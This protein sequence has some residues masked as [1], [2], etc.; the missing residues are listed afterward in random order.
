MADI[1]KLEPKRE[2]VERICKKVWR[3][4]EEVKEFLNLLEVKIECE[5]KRAE[6]LNR[7]SK[8]NLNYLKK[9]PFE[10]I[11]KS[12]IK[13]AEN[14]AYQT[15]ELVESLKNV[16]YEPLKDKVKGFSDKIESLDDCFEDHFKKL[17][18]AKEKLISID[19]NYSHYSQQLSD[20]LKKMGYDS[21]DRKSDFFDDKLFYSL[22][23]KMKTVDIRAKEVENQTNELNKLVSSYKT[24]M[25][26]KIHD[27][28]EMEDERIQGIIDALNQMN[29]FQTNC[30][31]NNKY[32]CNHF[33]QTVE[34]IKTDQTVM[35]YKALFDPAPMLNIQT[36]KFKLY[37]ELITKSDIE[38]DSIAE[39]EEAQH[40][41]K[42]MKFVSNISSDELDFSEFEKLMSVKLNRYLFVSIMN[43]YIPKSL[44]CK[45]SY[46]NLSTLFNYCL[47]GCNRNDDADYLKCIL[48]SSSKIYFDEEEEE[49]SVIRTYV[50]EGIRRNKIWDNCAI[51]GKAIFKDFRD[52]L[53]KFKIPKEQE[54]EVDKDEVLRNI[55]FNRLRYYVEKLVYF[56][57]DKKLLLKIIEK[58][59]ISYKF[60]REQN[61]FLKATVEAKEVEMAPCD[62]LFDEDAKRQ[63]ASG[64]LTK[65]M[66]SWM[67]DIGKF[68]VSA[69]SK[70]KTYIKKKEID[71]DPIIDCY[72]DCAIEEEDNSNAD[73]N[74]S[75]KGSPKYN[76]SK[77]LTALVKVESAIEDFSKDKK[78][79]IISEL[80]IIQKQ[81]TNSTFNKTK[82][83]SK[84]S[85][86]KENSVS[87]NV[88]EYLNPSSKEEEKYVKPSSPQSSPSSHSKSHNPPG[89]MPSD[90]PSSINS[91][92]SNTNTLRMTQIHSYPNS[93]GEKSNETTE[94]I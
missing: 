93:E 80:E 64:S 26:S 91:Q 2:H 90:I 1:M 44:P 57:M 60:T 54:R 89:S 36:F 52:I 4:V 51:W 21:I 40:K 42:I 67:N 87:K 88:Q 19:S 63:L 59:H 13:K 17:K 46:N 86:T 68:S 56:D 92:I 9:T 79:S 83:P 8:F 16:I 33:Y 18:H 50:T 65:K 28:E 27:L 43:K 72:D 70:M 23:S 76:G 45:K 49:D 85:Q 82:D 69:M 29:I 20:I 78:D 66:G 55:F 34:N 31:M 6:S 94:A 77:R 75:S 58:F 84:R 47:K 48:S 61:Q 39:P 32:D 3:K 12:I 73:T 81:S 5:F 37:D 11:C 71:E 30:D 14:E 15:Y 24:D 41:G 7:V 25:E 74:G 53:V 38:M 62:E 22:N 35:E 10:P